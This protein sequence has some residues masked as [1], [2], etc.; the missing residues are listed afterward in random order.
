M[1]DEKLTFNTEAERA[2]ALEVLEGRDMTENDISEIDRISAAEIVGEEAPQKPS[3]ADDVVELESEAELAPAPVETD[4]PTDDARDWQINEE[5]ISKYDEEYTETDGRRRNFITHKNP[6]DFM[7]SYIG[8]QKNINYLKTIKGPQDIKAAEERA[9]ETAKVEYE[10]KLTVMQ[11][12]FEE[13]KTKPV[14]PTEH[15]V[16]QPPVVTD[17]IQQYNEVLEKIKGVDDVDSIENTELYKRAIVLSDKVRQEDSAKYA[18]NINKITRDLKTEIA[19]SQNQFKTDWEARQ[20]T[21]R[22]D[23]EAV[24]AQQKS[25]QDRVNAQ[26]EVDLFVNGVNVPAEFKTGQKF[27]EMTDEA[28]A[29]HNQLAEIYTDKNRSYYTQK[30]WN[31]LSEKAGTLYLNNVPELVNKV[32]TYGISAPKNYNAWVKLDQIDAIRAGYWR[33]PSSNEWEKRYTPQGKEVSFP[34]VTAAYN[35]YLDQTGLREQQIKA[36]K[37]KNI[38]S[39]ANAA[40]KRDKNVVQL[41]DSKLDQGGDAMTEIAAQ[42]ILNTIDMDSAVQAHQSGD[43]EPL[44]KLNAATRRLYPDDYKEIIPNMFV[45]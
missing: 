24:A 44:A 41:D 28:L 26:N 7:K 23:A 11:K 19:N 38:T 30:D 3:P 32:N 8:A 42:E 43:P 15:P 39:F 6:D 33:N 31:A 10:E 14:V 25:L 29:F 5:L 22:Q 36:D 35:Y 27:S 9:K 20:T 2:T 17:S 34:D 4:P 12:E 21:A 16:A 45:S 37:D 1:P 40:N 18:E 13:I